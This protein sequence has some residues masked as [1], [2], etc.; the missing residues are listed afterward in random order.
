MDRV[1]AVIL[2]NPDSRGIS[3]IEV[4]R[5]LV[6]DGRTLMTGQVRE[7][8]A[9]KIRLENP[10]WVWYEA[11]DYS[12]LNEVLREARRYVSDDIV[13]ENVA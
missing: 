11:C 13:Q 12:K 7:V 9:Q 6:V 1:A 10:E 2:S 3:W 5:V 8:D 4:V